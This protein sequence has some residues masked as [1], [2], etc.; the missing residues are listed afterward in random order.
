MAALAALAAP[1]QAHHSLTNYDSGRVVELTGEVTEFHYTQPHPFLVIAV[2]GAAWKLEMDNLWELDAVGVARDTFRP[3]DRVTVS[4]SPDRGGARA[5]Y[6]R[7]LDRS[8]DRLRYEQVG[9]SPRLTV[10]AK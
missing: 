10:P 3:G 8:R 1:A 4:G 7:R 9:T 2:A 6:L 5:L